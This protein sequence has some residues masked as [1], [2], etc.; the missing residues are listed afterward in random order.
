M[1]WFIVALLKGTVGLRRNQLSAHSMVISKE[2]RQIRVHFNDAQR[3]E[4]M[5]LSTREGNH[6]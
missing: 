4:L 6:H 3:N 5:G 2:H 1:Q